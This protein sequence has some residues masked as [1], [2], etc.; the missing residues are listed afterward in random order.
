MVAG[1]DRVDRDDGQVAQILALIL[2]QGDVRGGDSLILHLLGEDVRDA[3]FV[4]RDEAEAAGG[5]GVAQYVGHAS[6]DARRAAYGFGE[7]E[8][9][10]AGIAC[11]ADRRVLADAFVDGT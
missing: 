10:G 3:I 11:I 4:D 7:D 8:I 1:V 9:A 6:T 2:I 5:E